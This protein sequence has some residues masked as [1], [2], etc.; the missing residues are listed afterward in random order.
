MV[1]RASE[2]PIRRS[3]HKCD[4]DAS[5]P[6]QDLPSGHPDSSNP[7]IRVGQQKGK[8][9]VWPCSHPRHLDQDWIVWFGYMLVSSLR[10]GWTWT[11]WLGALPDFISAIKTQFIPNFHLPTPFLVHFGVEWKL[12][13]FQARSRPDATKLKATPLIAPFYR[14]TCAN[15]FDPCLKCKIYVNLPSTDICI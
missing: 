1:R 4:Q 6:S 11:G 2:K 13:D 7:Q 9:L 3:Q 15:I 8:V 14:C 10:K 5:A 12:T